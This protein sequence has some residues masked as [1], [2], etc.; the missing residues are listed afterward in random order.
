MPKNAGVRFAGTKGA[1]FCRPFFNFQPS[2]L[3]VNDYD[4]EIFFLLQLVPYIYTIES[5]LQKHFMRDFF[6]NSMKFR[7]IA[8]EMVKLDCINAN[9]FT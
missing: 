9:L 7:K 2:F 8:S 4:F 3:I 5:H 1:L 6:R